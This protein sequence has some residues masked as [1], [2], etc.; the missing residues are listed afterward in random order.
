MSSIDFVIHSRQSVDGAR[1]RTHAQ[2][3]RPPLPET[4]VVREARRA[5][6]ETDR[7]A[8]LPLKRVEEALLY[9]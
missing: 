6:I 1:A 5:H 7:A 9:F 4:L 3:P 8:P 2:K